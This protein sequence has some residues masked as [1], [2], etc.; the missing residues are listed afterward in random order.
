[1]AF[2]A[3]FAFVQH[4]TKGF[5]YLVCFPVSEVVKL[6]TVPQQFLILTT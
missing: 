6:N 2:T 3:G 1:M 4:I 5:I